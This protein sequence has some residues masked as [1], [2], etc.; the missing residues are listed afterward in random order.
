MSVLRQFKAN[1]DR[2]RGA[3]KQ[4]RT[5]QRVTRAL[6][7]QLASHGRNTLTNA[8]TFKGTENQVW[9]ADYKAFNCAEWRVRDPALLLSTAFC[10]SSFLRVFVVN[11]FSLSLQCPPSLMHARRLSPG[12][13]DA[14]AVGAEEGQGAGVLVASQFEDAAGEAAVLE[15][16]DAPGN[17]PD[18]PPEP[19]EG[20]VL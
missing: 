9:S 13:L 16:E 3:F 12:L 10:P 8:I 1:L 2:W 7:A 15:G 6:V 11:L 20:S 18:H 19:P 5:F 17:P 4:T 14:F